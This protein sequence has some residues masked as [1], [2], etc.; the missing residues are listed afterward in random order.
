[1]RSVVEPGESGE[2]T[3]QLSIN[4]KRRDTRTRA[5]ALL[6]LG[7]RFKPKVIAE[8]LGVSGESVY[9]WSHERGE[10]RVF[11]L[12]GFDM[13]SRPPTLSDAMIT[14]T[15]K[16]APAKS[17]TCA[18]IGQWV[19]AIHAE[20]LLCR[21][22]TPG[23]SQA[24]RSFVQTQSL[25]ASTKRNEEE[26]QLKADT[27]G[28]LQCAAREGQCRLLHLD[29]AASVRR[30]PFSKAG[31][32]GNCPTV[33]NPTAIPNATSWADLTS[34]RTAWSTPQVPER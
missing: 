7:R 12:R 25:S 21:I 26:L 31:H 20:A 30:P 27:L 33:L 14:L 24:R 23:G 17:L 3:L 19:E 18:Q 6:T 22:E 34:V 2:T 1:M 8:P 28:E 10:S 13:G 4:H 32:H 15:L 5:A 29:S 16:V 9:K 11:G